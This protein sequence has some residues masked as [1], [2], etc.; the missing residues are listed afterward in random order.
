MPRFRKKFAKT[1][2]NTT[3]TAKSQVFSRSR[4]CSWVMRGSVARTRGRGRRARRAPRGRLLFGHKLLPLGAQRQVLPGL[5]G[6]PPALFAVEHGL[7]HDA[8][9]HAQAEEILGV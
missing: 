3:T 6:Q 2:L 8:P 9:D 5:L 4:A 7:P 1:L